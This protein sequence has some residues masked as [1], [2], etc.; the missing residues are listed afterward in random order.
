[1]SSYRDLKI[2]Q[3]AKIVDEIVFQLSEKFPKTET[4]NLTD[5]LRRSSHSIV[6]NIAEGFGRRSYPQEYIRFL[7]FAQ[8][9]CDET[10]EHIDTCFKRKYCTPDEFNSIDDKIDH[11]GRMLTL[12]IR[13]LR[14]TSKRARE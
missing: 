1:M 8:A 12:F 7:V 9:S 2:Y 6:A 13:A 3:L 4:Y 11:L 10:R 14:E 5:Q